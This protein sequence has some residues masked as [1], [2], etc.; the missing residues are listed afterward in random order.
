M[1]KKIAAFATAVI[2][3][4]FGFSS[5]AS[6]SDVVSENLSKEADKFNV[7]RQIIVYN[8]RTGDYVVEVRGLCSQANDSTKDKVGIICKVRKGEGTD[9]YFKDIYNLSAGLSVIIRQTGA[10]N[11][12]PD[13]FKVVLKPSTIVPDV[14]IR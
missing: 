7:E 10:K 2:L 5:C 13:Q 4:A 14:E 1:N 11:V 3:G 9:A 12:S 8:E 6:D